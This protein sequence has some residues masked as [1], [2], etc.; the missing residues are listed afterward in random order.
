MTEVIARRRVRLVP[1]GPGLHSPGSTWVVLD[2]E[3]TSAWVGWPQSTWKGEVGN[4]LPLV[5]PR[6]AWRLDCEMPA[7]ELAEAVPFA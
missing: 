7:V 6:F 5:Y 2:S 4:M 1:T 3:T